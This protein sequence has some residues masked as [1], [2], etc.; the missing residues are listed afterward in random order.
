MCDI[1]N[2]NSLQIKDIVTNDRKKLFYFIILLFVFKTCILKEPRD[3]ASM[4][5]AF[6]FYHL[7]V[8]GM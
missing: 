4:G 2:S 3:K 1:S 6:T 7:N 8:D 5:M